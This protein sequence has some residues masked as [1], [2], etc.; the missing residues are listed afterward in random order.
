M[1]VASQ[2]NY[3]NIAAGVPLFLTTLAGFFCQHSRHRWLISLH[4]GPKEQL[5]TISILWRRYDTTEI[6]S[7]VVTSTQTDDTLNPPYS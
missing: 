5:A 6:A 4:L 3:S 2:I 1:K 7:G